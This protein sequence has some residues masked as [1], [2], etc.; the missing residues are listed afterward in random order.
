MENKQILI[1][2]VLEEATPTK[3]ACRSNDAEN[4]ENSC[5]H[6]TPVVNCTPQSAAKKKRISNNVTPSATPKRDPKRRALNN[7]SGAKRIDNYFTKIID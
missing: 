7:C 2:E 3:R 4:K 5:H 1:T 6:N